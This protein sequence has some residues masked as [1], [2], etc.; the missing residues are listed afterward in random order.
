MIHKFDV[1]NKNKLD[2]PRRREML[3]VNKILGEIGLN[4][5]D[6]FADI[7]CGIGYFSIPAAE[8]IGS[9]GTVYALD[10]KEDM[11]EEGSSPVI[12]IKISIVTA[13]SEK[14][15]LFFFAH[16]QDNKK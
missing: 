14:R 7:G 8:V 3:P 10:V 4:A 1:N 11:I 5:E 12:R 2:N 13:I 16:G 6:N 9:Q 15:S